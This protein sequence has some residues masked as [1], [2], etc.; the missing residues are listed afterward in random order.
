MR[1]K[2]FHSVIPGRN[3]VQEHS[4]TGK[5]WPNGEFSLGYVPVMEDADRYRQGYLPGGPPLV[6]PE[7]DDEYFDQL[8]LWDEDEPSADSLSARLAGVP[9]TLSDAPNSHESPPRA[10][11]GL[12]GLSAEGRRMIRSGAY[13]L[14]KKVGK[15]DVVMIT[16]TVPTLPR[17]GRIAVSK[18]WGSLTNRLVQYLSRELLTQGR[19]PVIIGCV[20]IQTARLKKYAQAYLHLHLICPAHSNRGRT[21]AIDTGSLLQ[22]W[23][24][25]LERVSGTTL[26]HRPRI[27]TAIVETSVEAYLAKYLS[28]GGDEVMW[29]YVDDLGE[30]CVPGQWWFASAPM[31]KAIR[32]GTVSG[33]N[34]GVLLESMVEYLLSEGDGE[35]FQYVRHVERRIGPN[36]VTCG[37]VGRF[38][39]AVADEL[40]MLLDPSS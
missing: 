38:S 23:W 37:W 1:N 28:K 13:L 11:Y 20:E 15:E 19:Q 29:E 34:T 14:E 26:P 16:L 22:W 17:A 24:R 25:A 21:W 4:A 7:D 32:S 9:F 18:Q 39:E 6:T 36:L 35:G 40:R 30:D 2:L 12:K 10:K 3:T 33:R 8:D 5:I 27:E 31:R